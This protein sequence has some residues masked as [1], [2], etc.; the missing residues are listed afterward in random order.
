MKK[1]SFSK[2]V[3]VVGI[4]CLLLLIGKWAGMNVTGKP[5]VTEIIS[6]NDFPRSYNDPNVV[7]MSDIQLSTKYKFIFKGSYGEN[8]SIKKY[9]S[10]H[11]KDVV[12][13]SYDGAGEKSFTVFS[14]DPPDSLFFKVK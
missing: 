8:L 12:L 10:K 14:D 3:F 2:I 1:C 13:I 5:I 11:P 9:K 6:F 7:L 4:I